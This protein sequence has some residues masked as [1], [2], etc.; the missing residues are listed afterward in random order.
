MSQTQKLCCLVGNNK[1]YEKPKMKSYLKQPGDDR[2][3]LL[4]QLPVV[5]QI[6]NVLQTAKYSSIIPYFIVLISFIFFVFMPSYDVLTRWKQIHGIESEWIAKSVASGQ[7]FSFPGDHR[8]L[9]DFDTSDRYYPTAWIAPGFTYLYALFLWL[10]HDVGRLIILLINV[11]CLSGVGF[12]V[13]FISKKLC[14]KIAGI[15]SVLLLL[16][17]QSAY[18]QVVQIHDSWL[19]ALL[20]CLTQLSIIFYFE[21]PSFRN[22]LFISGALGITVLTCPTAL[23]FIPI[24]G[25]SLTYVFIMTNNKQI[26]NHA[27]SIIIFSV[28][29]IVPW[30]IRNY[31]VFKVFVPVRTGL[32]Q[33]A[34]VGTVALSATVDGGKEVGIP[35]PWRAS[36]YQD[37]IRR[38]NSSEA[39][40]ALQRYQMEIFKKTGPSPIEELNEAQRDAWFLKKTKEFIFYHPVIALKLAFFKIV[41]FIRFDGNTGVLFF[42]L[43][44]MTVIVRFRDYRLKILY[45]LFIGYLIPFSIIVP[46]YTRYRL[47]IDSLLI[48]LSAIFIAEAIN[49][50]NKPS[51][52]DKLSS[53]GKEGNVAMSPKSHLNNGM[54]GG[55][56]F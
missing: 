27:F 36:G 3:I 31:F 29:I 11:L 23:I 40:I 1:T 5:G 41:R 24:I 6:A 47:P 15:V 53:Y 35:A 14:N 30:T 25:I 19:S 55:L 21:R 10:F 37:A 51:Q 12:T 38:I 28:I 48:I 54:T 13:Y 9:F 26:L 49:Y 52:S 34:Y 45:L 16:V 42:F 46:Y 7:G 44:A 43:S 18:Y 4:T 17:H 50:F 33:I 22:S 20:I 56:N 39:L 8:W 2:S 32:G